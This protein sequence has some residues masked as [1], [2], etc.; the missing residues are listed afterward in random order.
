MI[1][2]ISK[3][4]DDTHLE[5]KNTWDGHWRTQRNTVAWAKTQ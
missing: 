5:G 1:I 3:G 4:R 2:K